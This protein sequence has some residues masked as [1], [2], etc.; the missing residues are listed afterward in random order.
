MSVII[1]TDAGGV[2]KSS[3]FV[4]WMFVLALLD[5]FCR[6]LIVVN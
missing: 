4:V 5:G 6:H 1:L 2:G 3:H